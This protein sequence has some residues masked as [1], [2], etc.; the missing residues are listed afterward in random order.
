MKKSE[1][2]EKLIKGNKSEM[3]LKKNR[4]VW[5]N[6]RIRSFQEPLLTFY[7]F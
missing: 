2:K 3:R 5:L 1:R 6:S 4:M 7:I